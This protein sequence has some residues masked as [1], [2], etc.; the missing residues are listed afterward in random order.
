MVPAT[1]RDLATL[2]QQNLV[3]FLRTEIDLGF[4]FLHVARATENKAHKTEL[5]ANARKAIIAVERFEQRVTNIRFVRQ[6]DGALGNLKKALQGA[7]LDPA[8]QCPKMIP[9]SAL[10][11]RRARSALPTLAATSV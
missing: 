9:A 5:N 8:N 10:E 1:D 2:F 4:T 6:I 11:R 7:E 3:T